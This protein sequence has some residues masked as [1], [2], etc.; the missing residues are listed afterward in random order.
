MKEARDIFV[1]LGASA[2]AIALILL[3]HFL[4]P[5][6][7]RGMR[8]GSDKPLLI[9]VSVTEKCPPCK[10]LKAELK[11]NNVLIQ[12]RDARPGETAEYFPQC[13][14][15]DGDTDW[16]DRVFQKACNFK[17]PVT[18]INHKEQK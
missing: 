17:D 2:L 18:I 13:H 12:E 7:A 14:Y 8:T 11:S 10:L 16:G 5:M 9:A 15:S 1:M 3:M 4:C 6:E